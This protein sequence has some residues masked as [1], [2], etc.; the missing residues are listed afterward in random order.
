M[1]PVNDQSAGTPPPLH[2]D[3]GNKVDYQWGLHP[4]YDRLLREE[5]VD[6][7]AGLPIKLPKY[8]PVDMLQLPAKVTN[9]DEALA[10]IRYCDKLCTL[11]SVQKHTIKNTGFLKCALI[12]YTFTQLVP[13]PKGRSNPDY[14]NCIWRT[15]IRYALQL[16]VL[17]LLQ[18]II[19]HFASSAFS[20]QATRSFDA[21]RI[22]VPACIAAIADSAMRRRAT[23]IPSEVSLHLMGYQGM[24]GYGLS[25]GKFADQSETIEVHT[26]ELNI[27]RTSVLDYFA[28]QLDEIPP[29]N[30]IFSWENGM[31][32]DQANNRF[33]AQVCTELGK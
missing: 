24:H 17:I 12:E 19:E 27:A 2:L 6:G 14:A 25:T 30:H 23:D 10:A 1:L 5:D 29:S 3:D 9:F 15:P 7:L 21:I 11:M 8:V 16:D 31:G 4:F 32:Q 18:R 20:L 28:D 13:V 26:A 33:L 22:I